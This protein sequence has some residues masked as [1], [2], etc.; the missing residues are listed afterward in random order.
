MPALYTRV[1][2]QSLM[3]E[4]VAVA[5]IT[6]LGYAGILAGPA[7]I[8]FVAYATSLPAAFLILLVLQ[9]GVAAGGRMLSFRGG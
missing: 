3:P 6:T 9:L 1:G 4:H 8:G 5:A 7:M 2:R